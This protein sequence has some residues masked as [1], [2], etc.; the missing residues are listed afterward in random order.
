MVA[1]GSAVCLTREQPRCLTANGTTTLVYS[2]VSRGSQR[3][4]ASMHVGKYWRGCFWV[5]SA[6]K[7]DATRYVWLW[8]SGN[9]ASTWR[10]EWS[11]MDWQAKLKR[12]GGETRRK[13][14]FGTA[15]ITRLACRNV[16]KWAFP[17]RKCGLRHGK[18]FS[19]RNYRQA[20]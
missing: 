18:P 12:R 5:N 2:W 17:A 20:S 8:D 13:Q 7:V 16:W 15:A 6:K 9:A 4:W 1:H 10:M 3:P 19:C 11:Q 14:R